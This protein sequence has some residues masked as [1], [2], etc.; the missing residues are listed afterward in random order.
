MGV[1]M[2]TTSRRASAGFI[3]LWM[4]VLLASTGAGLGMLAEAAAFEAKREKERELLSIG[5]QFEAALASYVAARPAPMIDA[6]PRSLED[7]LLDERSGVPKR[8]L[9]KVF[10]DPMTGRATWGLRIVSG[11]VVGVHSLSTDR[12]LRQTATA[13]GGRIFAG[14]SYA[15]WIFSAP[16]V[17]LISAP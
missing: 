12:P 14:D 13:L 17:D 3:Y 7:L 4:L 16:G 5:R 10:V 8:H 1:S 11:R 2:P 15:D 6:Y 9:R